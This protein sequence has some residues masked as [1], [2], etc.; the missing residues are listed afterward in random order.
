MLS[1][2]G[3]ENAYET[4][5]LKTRLLNMRIYSSGGCI[6]VTSYK[7]AVSQSDDLQ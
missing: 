1:G 6:K 5:S 7:V 3:F 4:H 2:G